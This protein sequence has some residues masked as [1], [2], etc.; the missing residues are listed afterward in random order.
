[1]QTTAFPTAADYAAAAERRGRA[2]TFTRYGLCL[3]AVGGRPNEALAILRRRY[4]N[5]R[6]ADQLER[7]LFRRDGIGAISTGSGLV[8]EDQFGQ[9]FL[10]EVE[11]YTALGKLAY[12]PVPT[13]VKVPR[14]GASGVTAIWLP[15]GR[16]IPVYKGNFESLTLAGDPKVAAAMVFSKELAGSSD[17]AA[18]GVFGTMLRNAVVRGSDQ[19][20]LDPALAATAD[21][22]ASITNAAPTVASSGATPDAIVADLAALSAILTDAGLPF[23]GRSYITSG[24]IAEYLAGLRYPSGVLAFPGVSM[25]GGTLEGLPL[26]VSDECGSQIVLVHGP[27]LLVA[28]G[29]IELSAT[30]QATLEMRDDPVADSEAPAGASQLVSMMQTNSVALRCIRFL[31]FVVGRT[32]A[33]ARISGFAVPRGAS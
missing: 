5:I 32:D 3:A 14:A 26:A 25:A 6:E 10:A 7:V 16:A 8:G 17:P 12:T 19:A 11:P 1:M 2:R 15:E 24:S 27:S 31:N 22:P 21:T 23:V 4:P 29:D 20:L 28:A 33:V 18:E 30:T 9:A 13:W